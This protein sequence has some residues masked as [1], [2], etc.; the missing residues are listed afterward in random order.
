M[1]LNL[2]KALNGGNQ[3]AFHDYLQELSGHPP[4]I[5]WYP[6]AGRDFRDL[7]FLSTAYSHAH[8]VA[9]EPPPPDL[10]LHTDYAPCNEH[11]FCETPPVFSDARTTVRID[12]I[13]DLP[14]CDLPLDRKI[15]AFPE[16]GPMTGRVL[17]LSL[18][19]F[20]NILGEFRRPL[21]FVFAENAAFCAWALRSNAR[22]SHV[23]HVRYGGAFGG[24][25]SNGA[26][27]PGMLKLVGCELY[28]SDGDEDMQHGDERALELFP[29]IRPVPQGPEPEEIHW[30]RA[31]RRLAEI[32]VFPEIR[33]TPARS[34]SNYRDVSWRLVR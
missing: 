6:S 32:R 14:R 3:G 13:E 18:T 34:W 4:R 1:S 31:N 22:F 26:W 23:V 9:S 2:L 10:F 8:P 27:I 7:L 21:V 20:S 28:I 12:A 19:V 16:G 25:Y 11:R 5:A 29:E 15:V 33:R 30:I 17:F 24:G